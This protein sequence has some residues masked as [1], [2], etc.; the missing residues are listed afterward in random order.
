MLSHD[1][2]CDSPAGQPVR[3][4]LP[5]EKTVDTQTRLTPDRRRRG[6][7]RS[8]QKLSGTDS[9]II[10]TTLRRVQRGGAPGAKS[11]YLGR[12]WVDFA[13]FFTDGQP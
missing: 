9:S 6:V 1:T 11:P 8:T 2:R 10:P 3:S 13:R 5:P 4:R 12:F 7:H